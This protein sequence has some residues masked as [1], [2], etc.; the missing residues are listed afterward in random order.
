MRTQGPA[1]RPKRQS[2]KTLVMLAW[3][4]D[5]FHLVGFLAFLLVALVL[6]TFILLAFHL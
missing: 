3:H 6:L 5:D 4:L 2:K 1:P